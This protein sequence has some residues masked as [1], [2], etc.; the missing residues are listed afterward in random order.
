VGS[1]SVAAIRFDLR[2]V[3]DKKVKSCKPEHFAML[4]YGLW[5]LQQDALNQWQ[6]NFEFGMFLCVLRT[7]LYASRTCRR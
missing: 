4:R 7:C 2:R 6:P 5:T 1:A 3:V